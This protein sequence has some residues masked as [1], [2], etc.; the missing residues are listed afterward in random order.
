MK[1]LL[2][3]FNHHGLFIKMFLVMVVSIVAVSVTI[4]YST[5]R[6]SEKLFM[7]TFSIT[8]SKIMNQIHRSIEEFSY[9]IATAASEVQQNGIIKSY[10]SQKDTDSLSM[11]KLFYN[12]SVQMDRIH[13]NLDDYELSMTVAGENGRSF[14]TDPEY[15]PV[16]K[17]ELEKHEV[18]RDMYHNP[19]QL[20]YQFIDKGHLK[21]VEPM[22]VITK[23][24]EERTAERI[25]GALYIAIKESDF[26]QFYAQYTS[27]GNDVMILNSAG[28]IFSSNR[29]NMIGRNYPELLQYAQDIE[30][31]GIEYKD[32]EFMGKNQTI[33]ATYLPT[34]DMYIVNLIDKEMI[35]KNLINTKTIVF[36]SASI[37]FISLLVILL[38]SRRLTKSLTQLVKQISEISKKSFDGYVTVSGS[39]ETKQLAHAFNH[40]LDELQEYID[41]LIQ[42]QKKQ[43]HAELAALQRQINPH[44]LY[45]TLTSVKIMVQQGN[46]EKAADTVNAL[47]SLLQNAVG[48][49]N[50]TISVKEEIE[51]LKS[52]V[53]INH[54]RY[55]DRINVNYFIAPDC[56]DLQ[57]PKLI[58]QPFIENAF[59]HG[60]T[61]KNEGYIHIA[62]Q[63]ENDTLLCEIVDNGDGM[64][65]E[66]R[67][68]LP[69]SIRKRKLFSGIGVRNVNDR[70]KLLYG[71]RY[72]V[73]ISSEIGVGTHI[74]LVLPVNESKNHPTI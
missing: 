20:L 21:N 40:M 38:I 53:F 61:K 35:M 3:K 8:N 65:M 74:K 52:Y 5:I 73:H 43:R 18:M 51:N 69:D 47:I 7:D 15:W 59:F 68:R 22:I 12:M 24:L 71:E 25:Y 14:S 72:G 27:E 67:D 41:Q 13:A 45:N 55:G 17:E 34:I 42:T 23:A 6:M 16:A 32:I 64:Q 58:I 37:V 66:G 70:I 63:K 9:S 26:K 39:Y 36:I 49:V 60:F 50:E 31:K 44:F 19:K 33:M 54:V 10:L 11:N 46:K 30:Q 29:S 1:L 62:I 28:E 4:T 2:E 56:L 48:N 57:L